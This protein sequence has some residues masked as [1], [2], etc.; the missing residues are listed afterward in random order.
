MANY[1]LEPFKDAAYQ[2]HTSRQTELWS[3]SRTAQGLNIN[4]S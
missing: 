4:K 1:P 3:L 2:S